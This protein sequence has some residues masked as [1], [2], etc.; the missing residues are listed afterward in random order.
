MA[1]GLWNVYFKFIMQIKVWVIPDPPPSTSLHHHFL[2]PN[3]KQ[4]GLSILPCLRLG[5]SVGR[6]LL[7]WDVCRLSEH[8]G[9][10]VRV[11][12]TL[13]QPQD[14]Q[15]RHLW[16]EAIISHPKEIIPSTMSHWSTRSYVLRPW[17]PHKKT[18]PSFIIGL[19]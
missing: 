18:K 1:R 17:L 12:R 3:T 16:V 6:M 2:M 5:V 4:K 14:K 13:R 19:F 8:E 7:I 11:R 10:R 15:E 9:E